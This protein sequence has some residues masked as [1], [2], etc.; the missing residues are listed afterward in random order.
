ME[1]RDKFLGLFKDSIFVAIPSKGGMLL[2]THDLEKVL[3]RNRDWPDGAYFTVNGF[4]NFKE[5]DYHGR[6]KANVTSFNANFL[7]IDL[8]PET[9]RTEAELIYKDLC[10]KGLQPT[11]V[12][13]TGKG[14][15]IYWVYRNPRPFTEQALGEYEVLQAAIVEQYRSKGADPQARDAA[16]VLRVPGAYYYGK[17][18][19]KGDEIELLYLN[20]DVKYEPLQIAE[21][22]K[23]N[24]KM[25][26]VAGEKLV[27]MTG[28]GFDLSKSFNIKRG[29]MHHDSYSLALSLLQRSKDISSAREFY[30]GILS[31]W[32]QPL[33][34]SKVWVQ[35]EN[36]RKFLEKDRPQLFLGD[37]EQSAVTIEMASDMEMEPIEWLWDGFIAK[38]K[39]HMFAGDP[40]LGKSQVTIDIAARL[41]T[42][43]PLPSRVIGEKGKEPV[44]VLILSAEDDPKDTMIPRLV[45]AGAD[46]NMVG[47]LKGALVTM[48]KGKKVSMRSLALREDAEQILKAIAKLPMKIGLIIIDPISA[49]LSADQ[50]SNSNSDARGTLAQLQ[51]TVMSKGIAMLIINHMNKNTGAKSAHMRSMGSTGWNAAARATFYAFKDPAM[52]GERKVFSIGKM[53]LAKEEGAGFFYRI[54]PA[55]VEIHGKMRPFSKIE[56]DMKEFPVLNADELTA[57]DGPKKEKKSDE[58]EERLEMYM[59]L[60]SEV[61]TAV[62]LKYMIE[63]GFTRA[64]IFR[65]ARRC[66]ISGQEHGKWKK[67]SIV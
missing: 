67:N 49:F 25:D 56:W 58:C 53:N 19:E 52:P 17:S 47:F 44:G 2:H 4:A 57:S 9:K 59:A 66:G 34:W 26:T 37:A 16:R 23:S 40:G 55:E 22:F 63:E 62:G 29:T 27:V 31:T 28:D 65:A 21:Y 30:R 50:D 45:A 3:Q 60:V 13:L 12:V 5:G 61:D 15:H 54:M 64:E 1:N 41:S 43:R 8:T 20:E 51:Y 24:I 7:D 33:D 6:T 38:G 46:L 36:A 11:T 35:F 42:G 14:L 48:G 18:G 10:D 39:A 32:E